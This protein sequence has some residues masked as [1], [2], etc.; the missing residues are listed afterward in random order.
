MEKTVGEARF[1]GGVV[2][3]SSLLLWVGGERSGNNLEFTL[4]HSNF[5]IL[6]EHLI[7]KLDI[8][9]WEEV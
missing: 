3:F 7:S 5:K 8:K 9:G 4:E 6:T 2:L 1:V